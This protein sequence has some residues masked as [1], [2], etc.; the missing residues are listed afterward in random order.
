MNSSSRKLWIGTSWKMNKVRAEAVSFAADL[1]AS[2]WTEQTPVQMFVIPPFPYIAE[3]ADVLQHT[4][5]RTG[6]QN[7][8]WQSE[9]AW[10]GEVSPTMLQDCG[11]TIV[12]LGHSERRTHFNETDEAVGLK[13]RAALQHDLIPLVCIGDTR[14]EYDAQQSTPALEK[15]VR[16]ALGKVDVAAAGRV[17][18]AYEPVWSIG[19]HGVA[20]DPDFV[21]EQH[22]QIKNTTLEITG[23]ELPVLYGGS[24]TLANCVNFVRKPLVDGLFIG[25]AAWASQGYLAIIQAVSEEVLN[26]D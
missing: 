7:M 17:L 12:E 14:E 4:S 21:N 6:A 15:Q 20:A 16:A 9:G 3:V 19:E 22:R 1:K 18:F 25:R 24:V 10:T 26:A 11:A 8:H 23:L 13:V 5:V 2:S